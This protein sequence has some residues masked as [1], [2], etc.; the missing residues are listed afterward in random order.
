MNVEENATYDVDVKLN[1]VNDEFSYKFA[2]M[3]FQ[4]MMFWVLNV[5]WSLCWLIIWKISLKLTFDQSNE[6]CNDSKLTKT[7][8]FN[9][10]MKIAFEIQTRLKTISCRRVRRLRKCLKVFDEF[11]CIFNLCRL[12]FHV[13]MHIVSHDSFVKS[14]M[15]SHMWKFCWNIFC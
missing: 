6:I 7:I 12:K 15:T 4:L 8:N 1:I 9:E 11:E 5:K 10:S 13:R 3:K 14:F 2:F